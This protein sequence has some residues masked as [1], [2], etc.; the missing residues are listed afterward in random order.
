VVTLD[1]RQIDLALPRRLNPGRHVIIAS[2]P[3]YEK[4][5]QTVVLEEGK[6]QSIE[7]RLEPIPGY[8]PPP[9]PEPVP[10]KN[11][12]GVHWLVPVGFSL[13]GAGLLAGAICGGIAMKMTSDLEEE[14]GG[15]VCSPSLEGDIDTATALS[16]ASTAGFVVLGV[17]A[18]LGV[19][20]LFLPAPGSESALRI[21]LAPEGV[22]LSLRGEM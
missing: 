14:C 19:T 20:G 7:L 6:A 17:G 8:T 12:G 3:G 21:D 1:G 15:T 18:A 5:Q 16:H 4:V 9:E 10:E 13:G 2:A 11:G 22:G